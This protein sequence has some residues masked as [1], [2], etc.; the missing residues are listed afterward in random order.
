MGDVTKLIPN[1]GNKTNY[2]LHYKNAQLYLS[3]RMRLTKIHKVIKLKQTDWMKK[4]VKFNTEKR[5]NTP[6]S[7][8]KYFFS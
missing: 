6:N 1:L 2:V 3:L 8:E 4:Y 5:T 7:F